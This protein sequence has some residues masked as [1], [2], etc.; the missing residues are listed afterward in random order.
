MTDKEKD[1]AG[2]ILILILTTLLF[3]GVAIACV[4]SHRT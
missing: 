4:I 2:I 1:K 3:I